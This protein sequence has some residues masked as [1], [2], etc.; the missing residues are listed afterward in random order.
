MNPNNKIRHKISALLKAEMK[1]QEETIDLIPSENIISPAVRAAQASFFANKYAE[2]YPGRRY[3][4]GNENSD[5]LERFVQD[6]AL[7]TFGLSSKKWRVNV[8]P[9]SGS[10]ANIEVY[11]A[12][13]SFGDTIMGL[14]LSDG[15]HLTHGHKVNFSGKAYK[16]VRYPLDY[17]TG[18]IDY[19]ALERLAR[20]KKPKIIISG[21]TA[22]SRKIDFKKIGQIAR[23]V[24]AYHMADISHIA[25][26]VACQLHLSPFPWADIVTT[27]THKTLRGPRAAMIFSKVNL[28]EAIDKAVFP[29]MQGGPHLN[30]IAAI[31]V[32]LE[33]AQKPSF[34]IYQKNIINN[35]RVL[36][37]KLKK[38]GFNIVSGGT[39]NHLILIDLKN[40]NIAGAEAEKILERAGIIA[41]RNTVPGDIS[42]FSPSGLRLGTPCVTTRHM[43]AKE[44]S[45]VAK[46]ID[47]LLSYR[48]S[49]KEV[50]KEI[51][52]LVKK[53]PL[54]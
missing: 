20:A 7:K 9:Y 8:Q 33:E 16:I 2:G 28:S 36:A 4:P 3:Y 50:N 18:Y 32:A 31:G 46:W 40:K 21:A 47:E 5:K 45:Q 29:G 11:L 15:G 42:P 39:D 23:Q 34:R 52:I 26:L 30:I 43:A 54:V 10:P 35:A 17:K 22:Y 24:G 1:R 48:R 53:F 25:G 6:L 41:N 38:Y 51:K 49:S 19:G 44:I 13:L 12:L 37:E 27:T 14:G